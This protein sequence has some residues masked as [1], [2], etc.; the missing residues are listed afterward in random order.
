MLIP[1]EL[2]KILPDENEGERARSLTHRRY[3]HA[4]RDRAFVHGVKR[5]NSDALDLRFAFL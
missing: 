1:Y 2:Q 3:L 5:R 4:I